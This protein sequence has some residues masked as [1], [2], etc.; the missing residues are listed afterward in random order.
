MV[1]FSGAVDTGCGHAT[2]RVGPFY[3]PA[4]QKVYLDLGFF[5]ELERKLGAPGEFARAYVIAH[6][7]GHHVQKL[8]GYSD[9]TDE[10][11]GTSWRINTR[12]AWSC[13]PTTSPACWAHYVQKKYAGKYEVL[14][15][16][17]IA[18]GLNAA[19]KI[20][21]DYLQKRA[22][23]Q[24][25]VESFTHGTSA[26]RAHWLDDG[27]RTG[28]FSKAKLDYFFTQ[29]YTKVDV[30]VRERQA[31]SEGALEAGESAMSDPPSVRPDDSPVTVAPSA[32]GPA[33]APVP[34]EYE[35]LSELGAAAWASSTRP[36]S[37]GL[38]RVVALKMILA[39]PARRRR[40]AGPVPG[41]GGGG[42]PRSQHPN[43]VQ[44][45]EVGEHDGLPFFAL[46][47]VEGGTL[48]ERLAER[49]A[50]AREAAGA[51]RDAGPGGART[52]TSAAS[53]TA[54]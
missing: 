16:K 48:A 3:C 1:L 27:M 49:P 42:R 17:D 53:S 22:T 45:Y 8:L 51:G 23:G 46:E 34:N 41:R 25:R 38:N 36:G 14:N 6:E 31:R 35:I 33:P 19:Q 54:T 10:K 2:S 30:G 4:D 21:D 50:A 26:S 15:R 24:I 39:G 44:V 43:I 32:A 52:P 12:C 20:G 28:D 29:P 40:R 11:R 18:S 5:A 37:C 9:R 7:V 13:R 47:F